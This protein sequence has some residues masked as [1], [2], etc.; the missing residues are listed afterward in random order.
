VIKVVIPRPKKGVHVPGLGKAFIQFSNIESSK[1]ART[2]L[3]KFL[4]DGNIVEANYLN[5]KL[6]EK[7][8][9]DQVEV[10]K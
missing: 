4:F 7:G 5:L 1:K 6:F 9:Y 8:D 10:R 2:E 3:T